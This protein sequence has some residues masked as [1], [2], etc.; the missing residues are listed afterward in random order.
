MAM[1]I[2]F[3][4]TSNNLIDNMGTR[5]LT[6]TK[7]AVAEEKSK[8]TELEKAEQENKDLA[9]KKS[10]NQELADITNDLND[11]TALMRKGLAFKLDDDSGQNVISVM[12]V[13]SGDII[14][15][16]P[17]AEALELSKKLAEVAG[18][19]LNTEA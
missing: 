2:N 14:R 7:A 13:D 8:V 5:Q 15:Q 9:E 18:I 16:I 1:D 17:N 6:E 4:G 10:D 3:T 19:L 11:M 12:D